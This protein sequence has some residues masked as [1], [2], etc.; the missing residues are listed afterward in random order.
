MI[1]RLLIIIATIIWGSSFVIVKDVTTYLSPAW[2]LAVRFTAATIIMACAL[3]K[4]RRLY[5]ERTHIT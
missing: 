3:L 4:Y 2:I 5:F 1:Y